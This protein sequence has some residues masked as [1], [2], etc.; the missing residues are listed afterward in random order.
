[1][2]SRARHSRAATPSHLHV[3]RRARCAQAAPHLQPARSACLSPVLHVTSAHSSRGS[4]EHWLQSASQ[5]LSSPGDEKRESQ[6]FREERVLDTSCALPSSNKESESPSPSSNK[7]SESLSS[8]A[9]AP[10]ASDTR[11]KSLSS[12]TILL[13]MK[14]QSGTAPPFPLGLKGCKSS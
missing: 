10:V 9:S 13:A 1:M 4:G 7:E 3:A 2:T 12:G 6:A 14:H 5:R 11:R 8:S